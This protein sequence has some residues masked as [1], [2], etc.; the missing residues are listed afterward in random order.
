[1]EFCFVISA[2]IYCKYT[3]EQIAEI[4]L[5]ETEFEPACNLLLELITLPFPYEVS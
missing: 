2:S 4:K 1:M 3:L 5:P